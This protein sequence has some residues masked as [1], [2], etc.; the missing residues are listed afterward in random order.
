MHHFINCWKKYLVF[1]GRARRSEFWFFHLCYFLFALILQL[2]LSIPAFIAIDSGHKGLG[3]FLAGSWWIFVVAGFCPSISVMVRRLH[4]IG[5]NGWNVVIFG[6]CPLLAW[7]L[8]TVL[9]FILVNGAGSGLGRNQSAL[10]SLAASAADSALPT[11]AAPAVEPSSPG[12]FGETPPLLGILFII[13][14]ILTLIGSII[15]LVFFCKDSQPGGNK[16]GPNPKESPLPSSQKNNTMESSN[17]FCPHCGSKL[18]SADA[19]FCAAC[20][21]ALGSETRQTMRVVGGNP[22]SAAPSK[23]KGNGR[24]VILLIIAGIVAWVAWTNGVFNGLLGPDKDKLALQVQTSMQRK[25]DND[26]D[27]REYGKVTVEKVSLFKSA[28]AHRYNGIASIRKANRTRDVSVEVTVDGD[29]LMWRIQPFDLAPLLMDDS[30]VRPTGTDG[31][32]VGNFTG[33]NTEQL[34]KSHVSV[35]LGAF[36]VSSG[37]FGGFTTKLPVSIKNISGRTHSYFITIAAID[38]A[39]N[40]LDTDVISITDLSA[41]QSTQKNA[42]EL[43][44]PE[45]VAAFKA[46]TFKITRVQMM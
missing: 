36:S 23:T 43:V 12:L 29:S 39:G 37:G 6:L 16:Y 17:K 31:Q 21:G 10:T 38:V 28:I 25:F 30:A 46:A 19:K 4:D 32:D 26:P 1:S 34:L 42:F 14:I 35:T 45:E 15:L 20:G 9:I 33:D 13:L 5:R 44:V 40:Q 22:A 7:L 2:M 41:G 11:V 27:F 3:V 18:E 24:L 8:V